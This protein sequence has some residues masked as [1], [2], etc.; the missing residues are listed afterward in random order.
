MTKKD[1]ELIASVLN[2]YANNDG[3]WDTDDLVADMAT[4]LAK[5]NTRFNKD[6]FY[7]ACYKVDKS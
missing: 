5:D 6:T 2:K 7:D 3:I 1:Y 4:A